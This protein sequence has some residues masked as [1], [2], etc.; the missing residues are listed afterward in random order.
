MGNL[1]NIFAF[2]QLIEKYRQ[3]SGGIT[4]RSKVLGELTDELERVKQEMD[5]RGSSMTDGSP[6]VRIKQAIQRL[7]AE[8]TAMDIRT[9]VLE[10]TLLRMHLRAR[11]ES[12]KPLFTRYTV[13]GG[14]ET[15]IVF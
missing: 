5:Q 14:P 15:D 10:H 4:E 2:V 6:V 8:I 7:K 11:E 1:G 12:Q 3:A 13:G 9:G